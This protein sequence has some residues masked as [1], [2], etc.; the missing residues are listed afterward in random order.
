MVVITSISTP[1]HASPICLA[2]IFG[3]SVC[4]EVDFV[5]EKKVNTVRH[6]K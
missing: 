3:N 4:L 1:T 6:G 2:I 5:Q